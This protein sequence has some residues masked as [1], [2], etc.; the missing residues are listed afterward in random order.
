MIEISNN[1]MIE[2]QNVTIEEQNT[3]ITENQNE[4]MIENHDKTIEDQNVTTIENVNDT[5]TSNDYLQILRTLLNIASFDKDDI[6]RA[7]SQR[8]WKREKSSIFTKSKKSSHSRKKET[9]F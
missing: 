2:D 9:H 5:S 4:I 6:K 7:M 1:V 3:L 8:N